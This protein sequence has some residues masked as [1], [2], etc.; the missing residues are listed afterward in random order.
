MSVSCSALATL[1]SLSIAPNAPC[2]AFRRY[3]PGGVPRI[4][5]APSGL[6]TAVKPGE[7]IMMYAH[8]TLSIRDH[9]V[10]SLA[11]SD[12]PDHPASEDVDHS[13]VMGAMIG[14]VGP[15]AIGRDGDM[16]GGPADRDGRRE[17]PCP[18]RPSRSPGE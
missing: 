3:R 18:Q 17:V 10:R 6:V 16:M 4:S 7:E 15:L 2:H 5:N 11:H 8:P 12:R 1:T 14:H 13:N 9:A